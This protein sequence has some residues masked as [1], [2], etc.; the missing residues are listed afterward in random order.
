M[1]RGL[2][3]GGVGAS[4]RM[5][6][7]AAASLL[8]RPGHTVGMIAGIMLGVAGV[9]GIVVIADTQ[10][11]QVDRRFDLQRSDRVVVRALTPNEAGFNPER[12]TAVE[13]LQPVAA[14]GEFSTWSAAETVSRDDSARSSRP[15][16]VADAAGVRATDTRV[17]A[18]A[19][20]DDLATASGPVAWVGEDLARDLGIISN[21][22]LENTQIVVRNITFHVVGLIANDTGFGYASYGVLIS[23]RTAVATLGGVGENIRVIAHVRP[24]SASA[25]G[26]Y[27][28]AGLDPYREL[29]LDD[30]TPPDGKIL[31]SNV[32]SDLR[33][34]GAALGAFMGLVGMITVANTLMMAVYQ[35]RRELGLRSAIGWKRRQIGAL[36]L[37]ESTIAG[38]VASILGVGLG[39]G[40]ATI[41]SQ[42]QGW[43]LILAPW[44]PFAAIAAGLTAS[45]VGGAIPAYLAASTPP[46]TAMR[47]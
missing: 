33:R 4:G 14:A 28:V 11:A 26:D 7:D 23:R 39:L 32:G 41:W 22:D 42:F 20:P 12:V 29:A 1:S 15:V 40:V 27:M 21:D 47:S 5:L 44:L 9:V 17:V 31:L 24:G 34:I 43:E 2:R 18:G 35:R 19:S 10:Q 45:L 6:A 37:T 38:I 8:L 25:V 16:L 30:V 13:R 3:F 36:V 46:M